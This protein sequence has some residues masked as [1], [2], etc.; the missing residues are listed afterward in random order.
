MEKITIHNYEVYLLD[1]MDGNLSSN[2]QVE[3]ELFLMQHPELSIKISDLEQMPI[4]VAE[5]PSFNKEVLKKKET[6]LISEHQ[7]ISYIENQLTT[8][9]KKEFEKS[10][11]LN[12]DLK[13]EL[14]KYQN[15]FVTP[16]LSIVYPN[17][18]KLKRFS[19][20][21]VFTN[22]F[23]YVSIAASILLLIGLVIL[24]PS[25][26]LNNA[27]GIA[28]KENV[29]KIDKE[30]KVNPK[31]E[32]EAE[33]KQH[34]HVNTHLNTMVASST[35]KLKK[36]DAKIEKLPTQVNP[37][38]NNIDTIPQLAIKTITPAVV[39]NTVVVQNN[40]KVK[41]VVEVITE[42]DAD[43]LASNIDKPKKGL[44]NVMA[45][46][47]KNLKNAGVKGVDGKQEVEKEKQAFAL[48][49][50]GI[51]IIHKSAN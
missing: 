51:N 42:N 37:L 19:K 9:E 40:T 3:L 45:A 22:T 14:Y 33:Y 16:D 29:G 38:S 47:L 36:N 17:K 21:I 25:S 43:I 7:Y 28:F 20:I 18:A 41:T 48:K 5:T 30:P 4:L 49:L 26:T 31:N 50:G 39:E 13:K 11:T 8:N 23:K 35:N 2:L 6:D 27:Q 15:T 34:Q 10:I 46:S 32:I 12:T 1:L 44:W 24:W